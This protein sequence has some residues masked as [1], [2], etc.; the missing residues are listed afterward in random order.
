MY[1]KF[2]KKFLPVLVFSAASWLLY[3]SDTEANAFFAQGRDREKEGSFR[4]AASCYMDAHFVADS[5]ALRGNSL[6]AAARS[7]RKAKLYGAEF[8][9]L[10]K[11]LR[12]HLNGIDFTQVT[13]RIYTI[14]DLFFAGHRDLFVD[15]IP[16]FKKDD[17]T[18]EIYE[19]A[20]EAAPC[21]ARAGETRLRVARLYIDDQKVLDAVRHLREVSKL[22]GGT[23]AGKFAMLELCNLLAQMSERGDGDN[24]YGKQ[25]IEACDNYSAQYGSSPENQ[26][27]L[28]TRQQVRNRIAE[29]YHSTGSYYYKSGKHALA[30]RYLANV[31]KDYANTKI[32]RSSEELLS[33]I[34]SESDAAL[35]ALRVPY[36]EARE[37]F[38]VV[39]I[40]EEDQPILVTPE[41]SNGKWLLPVRD[42]RKSTIH[43]TNRV[44]QKDTYLKF[45][46]G[47]NT[48]KKS[49]QGEKKSK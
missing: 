6:I 38:K 45:N 39:P 12:E 4:K 30:E 35:Q 32:A 24:S 44:L 23:P 14:G 26:W 22:H 47:K 20:L 2:I 8:D 16:F 15:W 3:A 21:F 34:N 18:Y 7:Y 19:A 33:R 40:P 31:V 42:L 29:R 27:V 48:E 17:R 36:V 1:L 41:E 13:E 9:C 37:K 5:P 11:L 49:P 25:A 46:A 43:E 28:K 10:R